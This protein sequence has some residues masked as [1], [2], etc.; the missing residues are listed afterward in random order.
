MN[1]KS[2]KRKLSDFF[3]PG[4][5]LFKTVLDG[6]TNIVIL[7]FNEFHKTIIELYKLFKTNKNNKYTP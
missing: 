7:F 2:I 6:S 4:V 5:D 1:L 3:T